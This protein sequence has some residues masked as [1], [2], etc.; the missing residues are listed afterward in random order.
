M[1][2]YIFLY[3]GQVYDTVTVDNVASAVNSSVIAVLGGVPPA[4]NAA[5]AEDCVPPKEAPD[6]RPVLRSFTSVQLVPFQCSTSESPGG[7]E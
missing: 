3:K 2:L 5:A 1:S 4:Y 7:V 6:A